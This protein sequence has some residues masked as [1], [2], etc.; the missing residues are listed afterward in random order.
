LLRQGYAT[1]EIQRAGDQLKVTV[2]KV[3]PLSKAVLD[4]QGVSAQ[5][6]RMA[7]K[8]AMA[9][10]TAN[11]RNLIAAHLMDATARSGARPRWS[12]GGTPQFDVPIEAYTSQ[13]PEPVRPENMPPEDRALLAWLSSSGG[14]SQTVLVPTLY[15]ILA[16]MP[17]LLT[18]MACR[19]DP[20]FADGSIDQM[21]SELEAAAAQSVRQL[22]GKS[23]IRTECPD[24][25][26]VSEAVKP[27]QIKIAEMLVVGAM[28][29]SFVLEAADV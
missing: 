29:E 22:V 25:G 4:A 19:L 26:F 17:A 16:N 23:E 5:Q 13:F 6:A 21:A 3:A 27:F 10:N 12:E 7:R 9:F 15:R 18:L 20:I 28:I 24:V 11:P 1:G 14:R 8:I 2:G